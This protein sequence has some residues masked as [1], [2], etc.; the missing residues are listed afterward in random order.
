MPRPKM[1][2]EEIQ[3][4]RKR[5]LKAA[6]GLLR[7]QGPDALSIRAIAD[8]VGVSHMVLYTYFENRAGIM[9]ALNEMH[10]EQLVDIYEDSK[11][12]AQEHDVEEV[13]L[14]I[15]RRYVSIVKDDP[16][17]YQFYMVHPIDGNIEEYGTV[18]SHLERLAELINLGVERGEFQDCDPLIAAGTCFSLINAPLMFYYSGRLS[19]PNLRDQMLENN[20]KLVRDFLNR[21]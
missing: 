6:E 21:G 10:H 2:D 18:I 19:N 13:V 20:F 4:M 7:E 5:I 16:S 8:R 17:F 3:A 11:M 12:I 14:Q 1:T 9:E 15:L